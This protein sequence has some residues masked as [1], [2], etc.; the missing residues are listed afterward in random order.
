MFCSSKMAT[1]C[2][3]C[4]AVALKVFVYSVVEQVE[5]SARLMQMD[6]GRV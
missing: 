3:D 6:V 4:A 1:A 5:V 2:E